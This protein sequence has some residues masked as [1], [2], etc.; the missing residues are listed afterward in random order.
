MVLALLSIIS[1]E[2]R[3]P[4]YRFD[5]SRFFWTDDENDREAYERYREYDEMRRLPL[6]SIP[7]TTGLYMWKQVFEDCL[8]LAEEAE[9]RPW[10]SLPSFEEGI[11]KAVNECFDRDTAGAVAGALLGAY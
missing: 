5:L 6:D 10:N 2:E 4:G 8:G 1:G 7:M 3:V 11:L 9:G